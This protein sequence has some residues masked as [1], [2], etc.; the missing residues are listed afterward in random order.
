MPPS[1]WHDDVCQVSKIHLFL[2]LT[3]LA[4]QWVR[5]AMWYG[6][7]KSDVGVH[8]RSPTQ[9][10]GR[11]LEEMPSQLG[12]ESWAG[13]IQM[14][15]RTGREGK[16]L[17]LTRTR[18]RMCDLSYLPRKIIKP[19]RSERPKVSNSVTGGYGFGPQ[20]NRSPKLGW[21]LV[22]HQA[23]SCTSPL[24]LFPAL[25]EAHDRMEV[26]GQ[27]GGQDNADL[28]RFHHGAARPQPGYVSFRA[29]QSSCT[30]TGSG[31][32]A[33]HSTEICS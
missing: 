32:Q 6:R 23:S 5:D 19:H 22:P 33:A 20:D 11:F 18:W 2:V 10:W 17:I 27:K 24:Y 26:S 29:P 25:R 21:L 4:V 12:T 30:R 16:R 7:E 14:K 28:L 13:M 3:K 1:P 31:V 8:W 15:L 9:S